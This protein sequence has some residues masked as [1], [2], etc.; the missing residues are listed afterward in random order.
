[1]RNEPGTLVLESRPLGMALAI[2]MVVFWLAVVGLFILTA[3]KGLGDMLL[4]A[5]P[6]LIGG[7]MFWAFFRR[8]QV[9][10]DAATG[11]VAVRERSVT[12]YAE[13]LVPLD[14]LKEAIVQSGSG[15]DD[16]PT[17]RAA[18]R[19]GGRTN[20]IIPLTLY[21]TSGEGPGRAARTINDWLAA[22]RAGAPG[23]TGP[24]NGPGAGTGQR[25][26]STRPRA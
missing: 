11:Q 9:W 5:G 6:A 10:L 24:R 8:S 14:D 15:S 13:T 26:K 16:G 20:R 2:V 12:G 17:G 4:I 21:Y 7:V 3:G 19:C 18:L 1:M 23:G 22:H 25:R